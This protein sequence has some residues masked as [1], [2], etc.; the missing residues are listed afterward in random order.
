MVRF[1]VCRFRFLYLYNTTSTFILIDSFSNPL[2]PAIAIDGH[3][4]TYCGGQ[5]ISMDS[6]HNLLRPAMAI[7]GHVSR[8]VVVDGADR[9]TISPVVCSHNKPRVLLASFH[10][11]CR[12]QHLSIDTLH[13][14][15]WP[16]ADID[17][18][19]LSS[20]VEAIDHC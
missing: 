15:F 5:C 9:S 13:S 2:R 6:L 8:S 3:R 17:R 10:F 14:L 19:S 4:E 12:R 11:H 1:H 20:I 18:F 7:D 16:T